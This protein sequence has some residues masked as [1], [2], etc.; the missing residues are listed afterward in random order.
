[1]KKVNLWISQQYILW[2]NMRSFKG[3]IT[4]MISGGRFI[5]SWTYLCR[6]ESPSLVAI[7]VIA[8]F[9]LLLKEIPEHIWIVNIIFVAYDNMCI[10]Q[11]GQ[12][13][14]FS[15]LVE[16]QSYK[17]NR[18]STSQQLQTLQMST[19]TPMFWKRNCP[20]LTLWYESRHLLGFMHLFH[21]SLHKFIL[22]SDRTSHQKMTH[23]I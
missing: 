2:P 21:E 9:C 17:N 4:Y 7:F 22:S 11:P 15:Q 1:M 18:L 16:R 6:N 8:L 12:H 3:Y 19:S 23:Y 5:H 20:M 13:E 14:I 10:V